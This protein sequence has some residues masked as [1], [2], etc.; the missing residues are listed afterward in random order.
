[1]SHLN[2]HRTKWVTVEGIT[3][4]KDCALLLSI[5]DD[6]PVFGLLRDIFVLEGSQVVF[7]VKHFLTQTFSHHFHAFIVSPTDTHTVVS[8]C[9]LHHPFTHHIHRLVF[10]D[11]TAQGIVLKYHITGTLQV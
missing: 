11:H 7:H 10:D 6:Y 4:K 8:V 9:A 2:L 5:E 1:M 3:Y